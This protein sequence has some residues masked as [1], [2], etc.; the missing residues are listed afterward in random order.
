MAIAAEIH[1]GKYRNIDLSPAQLTELK[2]LL[3]RY[4]PETQVWAFGSRVTFE[5]QA[6]HAS[7]L[8]MVVFSSKTQSNQVWDL[9]DAL[10]NSNLPFR[11]DVLV[12]HDIPEHFKPNIKKAYFVLQGK[13]AERSLP[14]GWQ[15]VRLGDVLLVAKN[16]IDTSKVKLS[17]YVSTDN[18]LSNFKG[19]TEPEKLPSFGKV[20]EYKEN[21]I[22]FSNIR[23]YFKKLWF[24]NKT[25]GCSNDVIVFRVK[26]D[27]NDPKFLFYCLMNDEFIQYTVQTSKGTKMPRG[28][29]SA[30]LKYVIKLPPLPEQKAIA[31]IL[32]TLDDKIECNRRM[33]KTLEQMAQALF[34]SWFVDFDPVIDN[35]LVAG[36]PIPEPFAKRAQIRQQALNDGTADRAAAQAF[37][38]A[39]RLTEKLGYIPAGWAEDAL[40]SLAIPKK[41][42]NITKKTIIE[43]GIPV[44]AGGLNPAYFH[45]KPNVFGPVVTVSASG[46]NAG[47]VNLYYEDIW[48]SDCSYISSAETDFVYSIFLFLKSRQSQITNMQQGAAQ[49]HVYPKDLLRLRYANPPTNIWIKTEKI[50]ESLFAKIKK[51]KAQFQTLAKLRDTL[52]PRLIS[53]ELRIPAAEKMAEDVL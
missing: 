51:N 40:S 14:E 26:N 44:V 6:R 4:L 48:A 2:K 16:K 13:V 12:W 30:I 36:N 5:S 28:D 52:L 9:R 39:F 8:D 19:I 21:D 11:V 23:T 37:P 17:S 1:T 15:D 46:A 43:G 20:S 31:H 3:Q 53:G 41:G 24:A 27:S 7:D 42:K 29:K 47:F 49:P 18:M 25:G 50:I 22:L 35:A 38:A 34:K 45:N 32:G 10:E 33:N